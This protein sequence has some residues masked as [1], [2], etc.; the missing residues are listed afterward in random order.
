[1]PTQGHRSNFPMALDREAHRVL[2][3][4]RSP[5]RLLVLSATDNKHC[6]RSRNLRRCGRCFRRCKAP[7]RLCELRGW[8]RSMCSNNKAGVISG[9]EYRD[10][11]RS[12]DLSVRS[13]VGQAVCRS[14]RRR[15]RAGGNMGVPGN[16]VSTFAGCLWATRNRGRQEASAEQHPASLAEVIPYAVRCE[17]HRAWGTERGERGGYRSLRSPNLPADQAHDQDHVRSG[18]WPGPARRRC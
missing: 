17:I 5:A 4:F 13:R 12:A 16:A 7:A 8:V 14:A 10:G 9:S 6:R 3:V 2:V 18:V 1:M 11:P 15:A